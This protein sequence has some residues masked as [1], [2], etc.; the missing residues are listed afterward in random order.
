MEA[1]GAHDASVRHAVDAAC[2]ALL[3]A[4]PELTGLDQVVGDGD[5]GMALGRGA[6]AWLAEP[7]EGPA[8]LQLRAL[9]AIARRVI[10]GTSGPLYAVGLLRAAESLTAD[11]DWAEAFAA[12]TAAIAELGGAQVGARTMVDAL[13]PAGA[14]APQGGAAAVAA[15]AAGADSTRTLTARRGRSSYLGDRVQGVPDPGAVAVTVWLSAVRDAIAAETG[16]R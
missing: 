10:G 15:A 9:S 12:G 13:A 1:A 3:A 2:R 14:A 8:P 5:L 11:A 6:R 16:Q 7:V 4:E